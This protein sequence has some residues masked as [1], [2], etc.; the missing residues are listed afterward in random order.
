MFNTSVKV[1]VGG[2]D[3]LVL[4]CH[5][6]EGDAINDAGEIEQLLYLK[7]YYDKRA[8]EK[9]RAQKEVAVPPITRT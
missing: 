1:D 5:K 7:N 9:L 6:T 4:S 8:I 3:A 2:I